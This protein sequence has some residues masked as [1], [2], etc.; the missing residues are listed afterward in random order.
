[1]AGK[2]CRV[3][4]GCLAV[5]SWW[6]RWSVNESVRAR[7]M[8]LVIRAPWWRKPKRRWKVGGRVYGMS[9]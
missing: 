1:M 7:W 9:D 4:Q 2:H 3:F 6:Q 5:R 8:L